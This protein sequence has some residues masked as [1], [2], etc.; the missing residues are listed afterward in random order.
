MRSSMSSGAWTTTEIW[1]LTWRRKMSIM[2]LH[3]L[4]EA[5]FRS[6]GHTILTSSRE[7]RYLLLGRDGAKTAVGYCSLETPPT[8]GEVEMFVSMAGNDYASKMVF[9]TPVVPGKEARAVL[10]RERVSV[11]DRMSLAIALGEAALEGAGGKPGQI[12]E[13]PARERPTPYEA[14]PH[15]IQGTRPGPGTAVVEPLDIRTLLNGNGQAVDDGSPSCSGQAPPPQGPTVEDVDPLLASMMGT[16]DVVQTASE[17]ELPPVSRDDVPSAPDGGIGPDRWKGA[18]LAPARVNKEDAC[19]KAGAQVDPP[20]ELVLVPH[21]LI[22]VR[23]L[24]RSGQLEPLERTGSFLLDAVDLHMDDIPSAIS[25]EICSLKDVWDGATP[26]MS[27]VG[28]GPR[29]DPDG[30]ALLL[31]RLE[32]ES[33]TQD[34]LVRDSLMSTV[35]QEATY[36]F[37]PSSFEVLRTERVMLPYWQRRAQDGSIEWSVDAFLG[38]FVPGQK[39]R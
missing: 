32:G 25:S 24:L 26:T 17:D 2:D 21:L 8:E 23:Y 39:G 35:Y 20:P 33:V 27:R 4:V 5:V 28:T 3:G 29:T 31:E 16:M 30:K 7:N 34:R 14:S 38:R 18:R 6:R 10:V 19:T 15:S 9:L 1:E 12:M 11:W 22:D 13:V 36:R 37:D